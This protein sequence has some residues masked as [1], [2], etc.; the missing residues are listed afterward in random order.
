MVELSNYYY[1]QRLIDEKKRKQ[2]TCQV[3]NEVKI[4]FHFLRK[5]SKL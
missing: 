3:L 1:E 4:L 5:T 2:T